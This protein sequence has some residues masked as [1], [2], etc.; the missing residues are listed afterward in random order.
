MCRNFLL[1][2]LFTLTV[3]LLASCSKDENTE[4]NYTSLEIADFFKLPDKVMVDSIAGMLSLKPFS[5]LSTTYPTLEGVSMGG[6]DWISSGEK[7][8]NDDE[9]SIILWFDDEQNIAYITY[10]DYRQAKSGDWGGIEGQIN[11]SLSTLFSSMGFV[12]KN[13]ENFSLLS[14]AAGIKGIK[15]YAAECIQTYN[16][17]T[18][19]YPSF[20]AEI[21]GDT[22]KINF[23]KIPVWYKNLDAVSP[24]LNEEEMKN[25]VH[26]YFLNNPDVLSISDKISL[27]GYRVV[28][29][30]LCR[31]AGSAVIDEYGSLMQAFI[32]IQDGNITTTERHFRD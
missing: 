21:E 2:A 28:H 10:C 12:Q 30:R 22:C 23:M 26:E 24:V 29:N 27:E 4:N 14:C 11:E 20:E 18:L 9:Q 31:R 19:E 15:W 5:Y 7:Y 3:I 13:T 17:D 16:N 8:V 6:I 32:D 1:A 25:T